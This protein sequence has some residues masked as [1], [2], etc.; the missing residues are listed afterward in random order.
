MLKYHDWVSAAGY[1]KELSYPTQK[2][3]ASNVGSSIAQSIQN[4]ATND[5]LVIQAPNHLKIPMLNPYIFDWGTH[6]VLPTTMSDPD[7]TAQLGYAHS[8]FR[9]EY[10]DINV[11][12]AQNKEVKTVLFLNDK[13]PLYS[14]CR[15]NVQ[16]FKNVL[17]TVATGPFKDYPFGKQ[18]ARWLCDTFMA[19]TKDPNNERFTNTG[20]FGVAMSNGATIDLNKIKALIAKLTPTKDRVPQDINAA[21]QYIENSEL[22][23]QLSATNKYFALSSTLNQ[24]WNKSDQ[25]RSDLYTNANGNYMKFLKSMADNRNTISRDADAQFMH[26]ITDMY[27]KCANTS[28]CNKYVTQKDEQ[29][30]LTVCNRYFSNVSTSTNK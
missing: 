7:T 30:L 21:K 10:Y 8:M 19:I 4:T 25:S 20:F 29:R 3:F 11:D 12:N 1:A 14:R 13:N 24:F 22:F 5:P 26:S 15:D 6:L 2:H 28:D 23:R 17:E 16:T 18:I 27:Y 9:H